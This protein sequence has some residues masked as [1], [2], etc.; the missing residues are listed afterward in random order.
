MRKRNRVD[1][2][3]I[4]KES[5]TAIFDYVF[6]YIGNFKKSIF[7]FLFCYYIF[8]SFTFPKPPIPS[9]CPVPQPTHSHFLALVFPCTGAYNLCN[10]KGLSSH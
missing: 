9:P 4:R 2:L 6:V 1:M 3:L 7:Y 5:K 10:T 8:S